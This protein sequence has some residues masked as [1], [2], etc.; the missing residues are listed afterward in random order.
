MVRGTWSAESGADALGELLAAEPG[1]DGLFVANDQMALGA[2]RAA[3]QRGIR[4]PEDLAV[5]GFDGL[6][7][8]AFFLPS[9]TTIAQPLRDLGELAVQHIIAETSDGGGDGLAPDRTRVLP[10]RLVVRES[11]PDPSA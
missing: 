6:E 11:A 5:V 4:I 2:L 8:G 10:T 9:L 3:S 1:I 7:E